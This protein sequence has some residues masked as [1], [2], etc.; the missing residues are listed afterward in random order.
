[1]ACLLLATTVFCLVVIMPHTVLLLLDIGL[2]LVWL[3]N[4][5]L[6]L[7]WLPEVVDADSQQLYITLHNNF[8]NFYGLNRIT[9]W[10]QGMASLP[11]KC[12]PP[13]P[14]LDNIRVVVIVWRLRGN[15]IRT[16]PCWVVWHDVHSHQHTHVSSSYRSSR[17]GLSHW[18]PYVMHRGGC[19]KLYY[20][21]M[22]EWC[23]WDSSLICKTNWFPSALW[24]CWF[25][26][27]T[28]KYR[29]QYDP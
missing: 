11:H 1:M 12:Q 15:I 14:P 19:L 10:S 21:N 8:N 27:M 3:V 4:A 5:S 16:A 13:S 6:A 24:H 28:C 29:P 7:V 26:H 23:W 2:G 25:G 22:V 17:L 9:Y 18:D 20:C